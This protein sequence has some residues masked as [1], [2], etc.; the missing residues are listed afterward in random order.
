MKK[1]VLIIGG[2]MAG[3]SAGAYLL[4][5]DYDVEIF[6]LNRVAGGVCTAWQ[7]G[8]YTVDLCIHWLVGTG[9]AS[10]FYDK[11]NE[12]TPMEDIE[13][14]PQEE[15]LRVEDVQGHHLSIFADIG[16]LEKE[17]L[18]KAPEDSA[19]IHELTNALRKLSTYE[20]FHE[21]AGELTNIWERVRQVGAMLPYMSLFNRFMNI[22]LEDYAAEFA[23]P[24]L[25]KAVMNL[26]EPQTSAMFAL[27]N[28]SWMSAG[29]AGYPKGGSMPFAQR[30]LDCFTGLGG[31]IHYESRVTR[32]LVEADQ[33][34]GIEL[35][36]GTRISGDYVI[37]AA[38]GHSTLFDM[39][40]GK[41]LSKAF[42][43]FY[44]H[45][46]TFPSLV[47]VA[48]GIGRDLSEYPAQLLFPMERTMVLDPETIVD[49][50]PVRVH[51][52]DPTLAP[53]G[54]TLVT[55]NFRTNNFHY[56]QNLQKNEP[57]KYQTEKMRI[58]DSVIRALELRFG[59]IANHLEMIDVA[60]PSTF[61]DFTNNW[62][63]SFEGWLLSPE[64]GWKSLPHTLP[65]LDRFYMC[66]QWIAIGGGLPMVLLSARDVAQLICREDGK[67][68][69]HAR[70]DMRSKKQPEQIQ[71]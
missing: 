24:L 65:G 52:F 66:G 70:A 37:S 23:N 10:S 25:Q 50:V 29:K 39:L 9:S 55:V 5:N 45:R 43:D 58:A 26:F 18:H 62:R 34:K 68:F 49:E 13:L 57:A 32:I 3:L 56:W 36:D 69:R 30:I 44:E 21:K 54:K 17:L 41:Y 61:I 53:R 46:A 63:G 16:R 47:F 60:T 64:T 71:V 7:R 11:W 38:D 28:L 1:K 31:K 6:E 20:P 27:L 51:H 12:L 4:M 22:S 48:L 33:A 19:K 35:E 59:N 42:N 8:D 14:C 40:E 67:E 2:G 15:F